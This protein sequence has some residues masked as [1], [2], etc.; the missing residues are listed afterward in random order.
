MLVRSKFIFIDNFLDLKT[1]K[2]CYLKKQDNNNKKTAVES[3]GL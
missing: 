3:T 2:H 1:T